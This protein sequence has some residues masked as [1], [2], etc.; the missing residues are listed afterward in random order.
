M[1]GA[2]HL[3]HEGFGGGLGGGGDG[4]LGEG[5][6]SVGITVVVFDHADFVAEVEQGARF[7]DHFAASE[8]KSGARRWRMRFSAIRVRVRA[9]RRTALPS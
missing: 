1:E 2:G 3:G 4:G 5:G 7:D 9:A 6:H 8:L